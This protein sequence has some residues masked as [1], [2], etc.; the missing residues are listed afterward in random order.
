MNKKNNLKIILGVIIVILIL[1]CIYFVCD[2]ETHFVFTQKSKTDYSHEYRKAYIDS[3]QPLSPSVPF[4]IIF[5]TDTMR[6]REREK[7][8]KIIKKQCPAWNECSIENIINYILSKE[9]VDPRSNFSEEEEL[10]SRVEKLYLDFKETED[11]KQYALLEPTIAAAWYVDLIFLS[12][13]DFWIKKIIEE[14]PN[15]PNLIPQKIIVLRLYLDTVNFEELQKKAVELGI[16]ISKID[17]TKNIICQEIKIPYL[18]PSEN[19]REQLD[20]VWVYILTKDFCQIPRTEKDKILINQVINQN[21]LR[22]ISIDNIKDIDYSGE[23]I[24]Y[25]LVNSEKIFTK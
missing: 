3:S 16:D 4:S 23:T 11:I 14:I 12:E 19:K 15:Y 21:Y 13:K 8:E 2:L 24:K 7:I 10:K 1:V 9:S 20:K 6:K 18:F 25:Y 22:L 5:N 17:E